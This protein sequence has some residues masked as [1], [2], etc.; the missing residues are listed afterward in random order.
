MIDFKAV[1]VDPSDPAWA[2]LPGLTCDR[3]HRTSAM[4]NAIP[5][6]VFQLTASLSTVSVALARPR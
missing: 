1:V 6:D 4:A 5:L 3:V 2:L